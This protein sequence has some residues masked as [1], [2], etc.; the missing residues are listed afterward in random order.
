MSAFLIPSQMQDA[1]EAALLRRGEAFNGLG[2]RKIIHPDYVGDPKPKLVGYT[3]ATSYISALEDTTSLQKWRTRLIL[4]GAD[5]ARLEAEALLAY[6]AYLVAQDLVEAQRAAGELD[7]LTKTRRTEILEA[8]GREY[9]RALDEIAER[10]FFL[11]GGR[12]SADYGTTHHELMDRWL[13]GTLTDEFM[14][15]TEEKW[16]GI[17][18]DFAALR[19]AWALFCETTGAV[20]HHTEA[21]VVNDRLKVAGRTDLILGC[22]LPGDQRARRIIADLK[23]GKIDGELKLAQQLA[24]YAGSKHYDPE[25]G[26]RRSLRVRQDVGIIIHAPKGEARA[27]FKLVQLAPGRSANALVEKVRAS[28]R[29]IPGLVS[30]LALDGA[31]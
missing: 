8:P 19:E 6:N 9:R 25:T 21:L 29:K 20:V 5:E 14:D 2:Q 13:L 30:H 10:A 1:T 27:E 17:L 4:E 24:M 12:D 28:R 7:E 3:R 16:P 22:K 23:T 26:Q 18:A 15:E 31:S 11:A